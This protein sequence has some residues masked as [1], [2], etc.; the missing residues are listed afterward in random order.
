MGSNPPDGIISEAELREV[1]SL[2]IV[3]DSARAAGLEVASPIAASSGAVLLVYGGAVTAE[4]ELRARRVRVRAFDSGL[5]ETAL[6]VPV[7]S[8]ELMALVEWG[9]FGAE[10]AVFLLAAKDSQGVKTGRMRLHECLARPER[11][12]A[13]VLG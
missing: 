12:R 7:S 6:A 3:I 9:G 8:G 5:D 13:L 2:Q 10:E 1:I 4:S 11:W